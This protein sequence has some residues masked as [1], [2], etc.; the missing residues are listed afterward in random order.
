MR[1]LSVLDIS[2]LTQYTER[3]SV[4]PWRGIAW[5][6]SGAFLVATIAS[7]FLGYMMMTTPT[8]SSSINQQL[9]DQFSFSSSPTLSKTQLDKILERNLFNSEGSIGDLAD[10]NTEVGG[11]IPK[12]QLPYRLIGLIYGGTPTSGIATIENTEKR[13]ESG[14]SSFLVGDVIKPEV[15]IAEVQIDRIIIDNVGRKEYLALDEVEIRRSSRNAKKTKTQASGGDLGGAGFASDSPPESFKEE[16]FERK[17]TNIERSTEYKNRLLGPEFA[18]V[19]QDAKASPHMVDGVLK[20]WKL[21]RIRKNSVYEKA[22]VQ[23]GDVVEE[24]NGIMLSDAAQAVKTLNGLRNESEIEIR[25]NRSGKPMNV[26][27]RVK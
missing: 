12:T 17:G 16:G 7:T 8:A 19:L 15:S 13:G 4:W 20:G 6:V 25:L 11:Q 10:P 24:I 27:F 21:D 3:I 9:L 1:S 2:A 5:V 23:N 26:I 18:N 14:I 22:G